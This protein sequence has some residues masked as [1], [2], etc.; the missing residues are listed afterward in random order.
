LIAEF[1]TKRLVLTNLNEE[2]SG[3]IMQLV[4]TP[5]WLEFIGDR[6]VHSVEEAREYI[7]RILNNPDINYYIVRLSENLLPIGIITFI[8]RDYLEFHDLGFAFLPEY[9]GKGY[10]FEASLSVLEYKLRNA[11]HTTILAT[12]VSSN[13]RSQKLLVGLGFTFDREISNKGEVLLI[14]KIPG[15]KNF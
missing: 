12:T 4:N 3:F 1:K 8:K 10:A 2:D 11:N 13:H 14:Y 7:K 5:G 15:N 6:N 9:S